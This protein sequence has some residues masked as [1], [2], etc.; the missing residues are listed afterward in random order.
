MINAILLLCAASALTAAPAI[1]GDSAKGKRLFNDLKCAGCHK[2]APVAATATPQAM[3]AAM[4]SH[5]ATMWVAMDQAGVKRSH[6]TERQAADLYAYFSPHGASAA[7]GDAAK[8]RQVYEAKLCASC[9]DGYSGAPA[10]KG[11]VT[12]F[13]MIASLWEHGSGMLSR[14]VVKNTEWQRLTAAEMTDLI[15]FLNTRK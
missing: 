3:A 14:M 6:L 4:W 5:A 1:R 12:S 8:G 13:S 9:H 15:A 7:P 2:A 10:L 11:P